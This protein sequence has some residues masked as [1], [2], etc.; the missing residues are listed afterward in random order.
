MLFRSGDLVLGGGQIGG[1]HARDPGE[2]GGDGV[3]LTG[4]ARHLLGRQGHAGESRDT[5]DLGGGDGRHGSESNRAARPVQPPPEPAVRGA[6][7]GAWTISQ[8]HRL[9]S[10]LT[11]DRYPTVMGHGYSALAARVLSWRPGQLVLRITGYLFK[12]SCDFFH[13]LPSL[14]ILQLFE[15]AY[16]LASLSFNRVID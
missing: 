1:D 16:S 3:E 11:F 7:A 2:G 10:S 6:A 8:P 5:G 12:T 15:I 13:K 4:Q 9:V 14:N